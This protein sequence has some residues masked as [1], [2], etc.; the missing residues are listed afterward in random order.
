MSSHD[1]QQ[2]RLRRLPKVDRVLARDELSPWRRSPFAADVARGVIEEYRRLIRDE[3]DVPAPD[4]AEVAS[5]IRR[6][7]DETFRPRL[8][9]VINA[10]GVIVHT[11]LGRAPLSEAAIDAIDE[12]ARGY[13]T[14]EFDLERGRRGSRHQLVRDALLALTRAEDALVANNNAAAILLA[15][16]ALAKR[17][18]VIVSRGQLVE[19]GGSFRIP[20][21]CRASGA[22]LVEVGTTNR[23]RPADYENAISEKTALILRVHPSNFRVTGFTES[24]PLAA[25]VALGR[26]HGI[27]VLD[28]LGSGALAD[29]SRHSPLPA[30]P[31]VQESVEAGAD[32]VTFSGDKLLAGPQAGIA[33]GTEAAVGKMRRHPLM[34]AVR[35]DKLALA[36]LAATLRAYLAGSY[37]DELP[38]WRMLSAPVHELRAW[39][40]PLA[41]ETSPA[42]AAAGFAVEIAD[43]TAHSGGGSLPEEELASAALACK[44]SQRRL[45]DL[46]KRLRLG[47]PPVIGYLT[48][49]RLYLDARTM[50]IESRD[51]IAR[52]LVNALEEDE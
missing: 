16:T 44:G 32:V 38:V 20:D 35:P 28:D 34:R 3:V 52:C 43:S 14:L 13:S 2:D 1:R 7:M 4:A 42:F 37:A 17:R 26:R 15:L 25:L 46:Q 8:R 51:R 47:D 33:A 18:E 11:N 23:T 22:K 49:A 30:E 45:A 40:E 48:G 36:A 9:R 10:T 41:R 50:L 21:I 31:L 5:A 19:I 39:L 24:V 6:R 27:P 12:V 29:V